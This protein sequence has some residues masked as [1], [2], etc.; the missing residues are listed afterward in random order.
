[1]SDETS[2]RAL[3]PVV[4][5]H[6]FPELLT[7]LLELLTGLDTGEWAAPV[8]R[9]SWSVRE[10][11]LHLLGVDVGLLSRQRDGHAAAGARI[12]DYEGLVRFLKTHNDTWVDAAR[13]ISP[14]LL[15]DL[16]R[17]TGD[18]VSDYVQSLDPD[19]PTEPVSWA[20]PDPAPTWL[21]VAREY[22]ERWHH[23]QHIRDAVAKPGYGS[24]RYLRPALETFVRALPRAYRKVEAPEHTVIEMAISGAAG[25]KWLL[26]R[27]SE[28][29]RLYLGHTPAPDALV[30]LPQEIAWRLFTRWIARQDALRESRVRGDPSLASVV[31]DTVAVIA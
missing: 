30:V 7:G 12:D 13:R 18:Q 19:A 25:D 27:E 24:V 16:L 15:C 23:Q 10:V 22:T 11:A 26:V 9:K 3:R 31:F 20:G 6:L 8:P 5:A 21:H 17:F 29:W 4:T 2:R 28:A 14:R 1:M